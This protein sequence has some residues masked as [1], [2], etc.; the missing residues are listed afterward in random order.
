MNTDDARCALK[1]HFWALCIL[2]MIPA[3][4]FADY[5]VVLKD[6]RVLEARTKPVSMEG[7]YRFT[8]TQN[9]FQAIAVELVD[10]KATQAS[11]SGVQLNARAAK[12]LTNDD[13]ASKSPASVSLG[14]SAAVSSSKPGT[15]ATRTDTAGST[16]K[17][18]E[19]YWRTQAKEIRDQMARIDNEI[20][21][22]NEKTKSGKS[23]GV[24]IGFDTYNQVIYANFE[25]ELKELEKKKENLQKKMM[26]LEE[27]ARKA[28]ALP[29]WLR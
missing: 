11:N 28:G 14:Q 3:V 4:L 5:K 8:D 21:A 9:R 22:L 20:K 24:K 29:G 12:T 18:G 23:D 25:S 7:H 26:A 1:L 13:I 19:A 2:L 6:G 10:Q 15:S 27:E 17:K 16:A